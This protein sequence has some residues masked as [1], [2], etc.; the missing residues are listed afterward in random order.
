MFIKSLSAIMLLGSGAAANAM[1]S[2]APPTTTVASLGDRVVANF[3]FEIPMPLT[4]KDASA[5]GFLLVDTN[6][7]TCDPLYGYRYRQGSALSY[8]MLYNHRGDIAGMQWGFNTTTYPTFPCSNVG[9]KYFHQTDDDVVSVTAYFSDPKTLCEGAPPLP[10]QSVGDRVWVRTSTAGN[11][12]AAFLPLPLHLDDMFSS[13]N[14]DWVT[15]GCLPSGVVSSAGMGQH[16]WY[17]SSK[18]QKD[19]MNALPFFLT[20]DQSGQLLM[21][22]AGILSPSSVWPTPDGKRE[23]P[24]SAAVPGTIPAGVVELWEYPGQPMISSFFE[25][26]NMPSQFLNINSADPSKLCG[27]YAA[28]SM[29]VAFRGANN[30]SK[31]V[32]QVNMTDPVNKASISMKPASPEFRDIVDSSY[33]AK[34]VKATC[35]SAAAR[36]TAHM[37]MRGGK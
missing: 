16:Y 23:N 31:S 15:Q 21:I 36:C 4:R 25:S 3:G 17:H 1:L 9:S 24:T 34:K 18:Y 13:S 22:G 37:R 20:F 6:S 29:H 27:N 19:L 11:E 33:N 35:G 32:C 8:T 26:P 7:S 28:V 2:D 10:P 30:V 14:T 5:S 12:A